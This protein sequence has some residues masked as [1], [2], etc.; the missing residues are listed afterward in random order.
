MAPMIMAYPGELTGVAFLLM[1][2][3]AA[4]IVGRL[5][6]EGHGQDVL[7]RVLLG[8]LALAFL[9]GFL[10]RV[11]AAIAIVA[12]VALI[13]NA[14]G[15]LSYIGQALALAALG[16]VGPGAYSVDARLFGRRVIFSSGASAPHKRE[17]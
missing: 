1:R 5:A 4:L 2:A 14:G 16:L 15:A 10:T 13:P 8:L 3:H 17:L 12:L 11:A 9:F 7:V 6:L